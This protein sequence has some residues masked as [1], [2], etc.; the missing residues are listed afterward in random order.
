MHWEKLRK[1]TENPVADGWLNL[2]EF[3]Q[4]MLVSRALS[5]QHPENPEQLSRWLEAVVRG[6]NVSS[7]PCIWSGKRAL[8]RQRAPEQRHHLGGAGAVTHQPL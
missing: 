6:W 5:G 7:T 8:R 2:A 3:V 4:R 1:Y